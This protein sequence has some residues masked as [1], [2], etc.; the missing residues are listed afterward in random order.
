MR[1]RRRNNTRARLFTRLERLEPRLVLSGLPLITELMAD[2]ASTLQD[3]DGR[4]SDWIEIHNPDPADI[5]LSGWYLTDTAADLTRWEFP[6]V[7]LPGGGHL[8][9]FAS[10]RDRTVGQLHTNFDLEDTGEFLA[11]VKPDGSTVVSRFDP[12][13]AALPDVAYGLSTELVTDT[14]L[15]PGAAARVLIPQDDS[16]GSSWT[17]PAFDDDGWTHGASGVGFDTEGQYGALIGTD[18]ETAMHGRNASAFV[19]T[20]FGLGDPLSVESLTLH[21]QYDDGYV[22]YLNGQEVGRRNVAAEPFAEWSHRMTLTLDNSG[23]TTVDL[24]DFPVLVKLTPER[25]GNYAGFAPDGAD[26]RFSDVSGQMLDYEIDTWNPG[27]DSYVW[28][29]V[30]RIEAGGTT[31]VVV[32]HWGNQTAADAQNAAA[33]WSNG[34]QGVWHLGEAVDDETT[35][36]THPDSTANRFDGHQVRNASSDGQIGGGQEFDG[37][38]DYVDVTEEVI[39]DGAAAYSADVWFNPSDVGGTRQF[40]FESSQDW[41][42]SLELADG[43]NNLK[44][45]VKTT[46]NSPIEQSGVRP[47]EGQWHHAAVTYDAAA[48]QT[49]LFYN[50]QELVAQAGSPTGSLAATNGFHIGTY[51]NANG[52]WFVG[53][54]DEMRVSNTVRSPDW[55]AAQ[56]LSET[57]QFIA[58]G[59][60]AVSGG[61]SPAWNAAAAADRPAVDAVVFEPLV[62][63]DRVNLLQEGANVLAVQGLNSSAADTDFLLVPTVDVQTRHV[64]PEVPGHLFAPSPGSINGRAL[65]D[66]QAIVISEFSADNKGALADEDGDYPDWIEVFN[67]SEVDVNLGGWYLTDD[68]NDRDRWAFPDV[69]LGAGEYL[70][71][72]ASGKDRAAADSQLHTGFKLDD[73]GEYLGLILPDGQSAAWEYAPGYPQQYADVS[74]GLMLDV[75]TTELVGAGSQAIAIVPA[76]DALGDDWKQIG[77]DDAFWPG[78]ETGIG[79]ETAGAG[80]LYADSIGLD[81]ESA[82]YG[83][84]STAYLRVPFDVA[85]D[86]AAVDSLQLTVQ[87]DDG[88][89]AHL[90][91]T[92][93]VRRNAPDGVT[94]NSAATGTHDALLPPGTTTLGRGL[95]A[96]WAFDESN[97]TTA[98]NAASVSTGLDGALAGD[99]AFTLDGKFGNAVTLDGSGDYV[100]VAQEMFL[101]GAEAY[102]VAAWFN[103]DSGGPARQMIFESSQTWAVS[104]ELSQN[105]LRIK[106]S[107]EIDGTSVIQETDVDPIEG[108]WYHVA[109]AYQEDGYTK[110][111]VNGQELGGFQGTPAGSLKAT[112]GFHVGTYRNANDRWFKGRIDDVGVWNRPLSAAEVA[113]LWNGGDGREIPPSTTETVERIDLTGQIDLLAQG[114]NVLAIQ[115]LNRTVGDADLL[116]V[117]RLEAVGVL[118]IQTDA[119]WYFA[120]PTPGLAN[121]IGVDAPSPMPQF[122]IDSRS[123]TG[124]LQ[125][126]LTV[127]SETAEIHYTLDG[128]EPTE[129][130]PVFEGPIAIT[131]TTSARAKAFEPGRL[132][133]PT[134]SETFLSIDAGIAGFDSDVPIMVIDTFGSAVPGTTSITRAGTVTSL[135]EPDVGGRASILDEAGFTGSAGIRVRGSSSARID[136]LKKNY[137]LEIWD[138]SG[139]DLN[140]PLGGLPAESDW[141]LNASFLDRSLIRENLV[142][143]LGNQLGHY[144]TRTRYVEVFLNTDG[145]SVDEDDYVG[146]YFIEERVKRDN[147]RVDIASL[148]PGDR[149]EPDVTGGYIVKKDRLDPGDAG[150][151]LDEGGVLAFVYPKEEDITPEQSEYITGYFADFEAALSGPNSADPDLGYANFIDVDSW[152][153]YHVVSELAYNIDAFWLSTYLHKD[154]EG[155]LAMGPLWD[156]D[157]SLGNTT[158]SGGST[159]DGWIGEVLDGTPG[160][161]GYTR[162]PWWPH[163]FDDPDFEQTWIDRWAELLATTFSQSNIESIIDAKAAELAEAQ[164]RNFERWPILDA[165]LIVSPIAF[166]TWHEHVD[167]LKQWIAQRLVWIEAQ[168]IPRP[169]MNSAGGQVEPGFELTIGA[170]QGSIYFTTDGSDPRAAGGAPA[171]TLYENPLVVTADTLVKARSLVGNRWSALREA[172]FSINPATAD[173][174]AIGEI[175]YN[176]APPTDAELLEMPALDNDDFEFIELTNVAAEVIGLGDVRFAPGAPVDFAF[177]EGSIISLDPGETVLVVSDRTAF[178][179][180]F[181]SAMSHRIAGEFSAGRIRNEGESI[182]LLDAA[183][184]TIHAFQYNDKSPW[185]E[186]ADGTGQSLQLINA[187]A[188]LDHADPANWVAARPTPG[189]ALPAMVVDRYVFYAGTTGSDDASIARDKTALLPGQTATAANYTNYGGGINGVMI[190]VARHSTANA[191]QNGHLALATGNSDDPSGWQPVPT[192]T[193]TVRPGGGRGGA[194]RVVLTWDTGEVANAWLQIIVPANANTGLSANDVFYFGNAVGETANDPSNALVNAADV[195]AIRDNPR[196]TANPASI[197]NPYDPNRDGRVDSTDLVLARNNATSPTS[198]LRLLKLSTA[199]TAAPPAASEGRGISAPGER[200]STLATRPLFGTNTLS[201][202]SLDRIMAAQVDQQPVDTLLPS[203]KFSKLLRRFTCCRELERWGGTS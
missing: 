189:T 198:A 30:P 86:P 133:S 39:P 153:D 14:V 132:P 52:R 28:V 89:V 177:N 156:F 200:E 127:D 168:F 121:S 72:F 120:A 25:T 122:S 19:R 169:E 105:N 50:G 167:H 195:I 157:R 178:E 179:L 187:G 196:G 36:G 40:L 10:G 143:E 124:S 23:Q 35:A 107:V 22:A 192:P 63:D 58:F 88:F 71:V 141:V 110:I 7:M 83:V 158:Q 68:S 41:T 98:D 62:L 3:E 147:D 129:T 163:L 137:S 75:E 190:D 99:A 60:V 95:V 199:P 149:T 148:A 8:L 18:V 175:H 126:D 21:V 194:D 128:S 2:N 69:E 170:D 159:P 142:F 155:K 91:G 1:R 188:N 171:G 79:F 139:N 12:F 9:V 51:R 55:Y 37:N 186:A 174:L 180:R 119:A 76:D 96:H 59:A 4:F 161:D 102:T 162:Y 182:T 202:K 42:I 66:L 32:A 173:N 47:G 146:V 144:A 13:P 61:S 117:P 176:P 92:E 152:I 108:Q 116:I 29:K 84:N 81:L 64:V 85:G 70:V 20:E 193:V 160:F 172:A 109:L 114:P 93:V 90:N 135:I 191:I 166:D 45:S 165:P 38:A 80:P 101:D 183:G 138:S 57:D 73:R 100:D 43:T 140:V 54:L 67:S 145:G 123:F 197:D 74:Y 34:F 113:E 26:L 115:A 125:F 78:G 33:V 5:D 154:R 31:G 53:L 111:F 201:L 104:V 94:W 103:A 6:A 112:D 17:Q 16:L 97:G 11:L 203:L 15:A 106:Y 46:G 184:G 181:G 136:W 131:G 82:M 27:G 118:G 151:A 185:P 164:S 56:Y 65:V 44:Y 49:R 48:G 134:A 130:S 77:F 150:F 24:E 87:Y